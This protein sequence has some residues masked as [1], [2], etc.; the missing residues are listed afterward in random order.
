MRRD[1][2]SAIAATIVFTV[3]CGLA[4]PL[5]I[6]GLAQGIFHGHAE[7]SRI[8]RNGKLVG[9]KIVGQ[10]FQGSPRYL[11]S[12]PS[13]TNYA[14]N[15]TAASNA[16]PNSKALSET[17]R[18]R[19]VAYLALEGP[20]NPSLTF[21]DIPA[22]AVTAS[23]SGI[24]PHISVANAHIQAGRV[25]RARGLSRATVDNVIKANTSGRSLGFFGESVVN[26]L[27]TNLALDQV[28]SP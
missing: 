20:Y 13:A 6:T 8:E 11:Q 12:R 24:D 19:A 26:V 9:S 5:F 4:Y 14:A 17:I 2:I 22:D 15:A 18:Q 16:G 25:A 23:G 7:A 1:F 10:N 27:T 3:L 28:K 21:K